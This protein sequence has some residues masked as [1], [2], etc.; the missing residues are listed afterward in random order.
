MTISNG[1][2]QTNTGADLVASSSVSSVN[3]IYNGTLGIWLVISGEGFNST[4]SNIYNADGILTG[5]R[6]L[7]MGANNL[8]L[9]TTSGTLTFNSSA[10][11]GNVAMGVNNLA[12]GT[13]GAAAFG[14]SDTANGQSSFAGGANTKASG[15]FSVALGSQNKATNNFAVALGHIT[16]ASGYNS[17]AMGWATTA[18]GYISTALG[19]VNTAPS[20]AETVLG[21]YNTT[22]TPASSTS[23]NPADRL[24]DIGNGTF[25]SPSDAFTILKNGNVGIGYSSPSTTLQVNGTT[26]T[27]RLQVTN[28]A[29]PGY[30]LTSDASGNA[31]WQSTSSLVGPTGPTGATGADGIDGSAGPAGPTGATGA[32]GIDG[33]TGAT[34][35]T[36]PTGAAGTN[37]TNGATGAT[38]P[39]GTAGTNGTNG[40]TGA[41]GPTGTA[42]TNGA[43][44]ATGA[45]GPTGTAGTNGTNGATGATGPTGTAGTN[46]TNGA[47]GATGPTGTAGTNGTNGATGATGPTGTAGANG[48]NGAT[49][50]TGPT[51]TAGANGATGTA[52]TNGATGATGPTG[53]APSGTG[54]VTVT[55]GALNTPALLTGDVN[56]TGSG[57]ATTVAGLRGIP[58]SATAPS[59]NNILQYNGSQWIPINPDTLNTNNIYNTDAALT[60]NR[61]VTMGADNL[62]LSATSGTLTF[63][64]S[65]ANGNVAMGVSNVATGSGGAAAFGSTDTA[66]GTG[67]FAAGVNS[68]A[69][70]QYS[71]AMGEQ[72]KASGTAGS[73]AMGWNSTASNTSTAMG[74]YATAS[75]RSTAIG[76]NCTAMTYSTAIGWQCSA[77]GGICTALGAV[78]SATGSYSTVMGFQNSAPSYGET[79]LG[80]FNTTYTPTSTSLWEATDRLFSIGNGSSPTSLSTALTILKNGNMGLSNTSPSTLLQVGS[81]SNPVNGY[82]TLSAGN[83]AEYRSWQIGVPYGGTNTASPNYGFTITDMAYPTTP[84]LTIDYA[85]HNLG[86]ST[87]SPAFPLDVEAIGVGTVSGAYF[88][89]YVGTTCV[90][91]AVSG[92][93]SIS[94]RA[95]GFV[96]AGFGYIVSSD[97]RIKRIL[98]QS[99]GTDDLGTLESIKIT[100]YTMKDSVADNRIYKKVIA[101][102]L[103]AVYPQAVTKSTGFIPDIYRLAQMDSGFIILSTS[104]KSGDKVKLILKDKTIVTGVISAGEKGFSIADKISGEVFVYGR[105]VNDFRNVDYDAISMLNV[106]ATQELARRLIAAET[107]NASLEST[108]NE[109]KTTKADASDVN[110]LKAEIET[111][112][113]LLGSSAEK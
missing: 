49:G 81:I 98:G 63:N 9:S 100:D 39:T 19:W 57:L 107:K 55:S 44:G 75:N 94:I 80:V 74:Y 26:S 62:T 76:Y 99:N 14:S 67:S 28:G 106:S 78:V 5:N 54:I 56:S 58:I 38:G 18:S 17:T 102:Q 111:L 34:G 91:G 8:T 29:N 6:T 73:T 16:T 104:L 27:T 93:Q 105:E 31:T 36:G 22:Y 109:L 92:S 23:W 37:G 59:A 4:A 61:T 65:T 45:T 84:V 3:L 77:T 79:A 97:E 53:P 90:G 64:S 15:A 85:T 11:H 69:I 70:G 24:F 21:T 108:V 7:T 101:Q 89:G 35:A 48:T 87:T 46:G 10:N 52:G 71:V 47:T 110:Q 40:A 83:G 60:G 95:S 51:G 113:H 86:L 96:S 103:E 66:S 68:N 32:D 25:S 72:N 20:F 33:A 1:S 30:V 12:T 13:G 43:N 88:N 112:K 50:A 41:T 42:G 2:I 82:M